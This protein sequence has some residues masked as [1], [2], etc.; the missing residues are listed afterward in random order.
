MLTQAI[1]PEPKNGSLA[2]DNR[3]RKLSHPARPPP[4]FWDNLSEIPLTRNALRG[5][6]RRNDEIARPNRGPPFKRAGRPVARR[7]ATEFLARCAPPCMSSNQSS[8]DRRKRGSAS[9]SKS[10]TI[11]DTKTT[12]STGPYDCAF[13]QHLVDFGIYPNTYEYLSGGV[14]PKPENMEEIKRMLAQPRPSLS[15]SRFSEEDFQKFERADAHAVKERQVMTSVDPILEGDVGD[16]RCVAG[17][18]P[19]TNLDHLTDESLVPGNTDLYYGARPKRLDR[20]V[21]TELNGRITPSTQHDL[22]IAPDFFLAAKGPDGSLAVAQ[23]QACYDGTLGAMGMRDLLSHLIPLASL[24]ARPEY[25]M[26]QIK[27][28]S[29]TSDYDAYRQGAAAYRNGRDWAKQRRDEAIEQANE[30]VASVEIGASPPENNL[31]LSFAT[32]VSVDSRL[33]RASQDILTPLTRGSNLPFS[34]ND[35]DPPAD[36]LSLDLG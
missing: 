36:E 33:R 16:S 31:S 7:T 10:K 32:E 4:T 26:T 35:S 27:A 24:K 14:P 12:K 1:F 28:Y 13:Q 6:N 5:L 23:R 8:L 9:P 34:V 21:R 30:K 17:E 25:V 11:S 29:L 22:P 20:Q 3:Q 19:F 18:I 2:K 15:P